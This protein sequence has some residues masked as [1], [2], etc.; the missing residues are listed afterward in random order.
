LPTKLSFISDGVV[1]RASVL[2]QQLRD[3]RKS[4]GVTAMATAEAAGMSR[5]TWHRIEKGA[6]SVTLG[7]WLSAVAVLGLDAE[8]RQ[9]PA[10][11]G[12]STT[13]PSG[14]ESIP[15]R[16]SFADYP[17]LKLLAWQVQGVDSLSPREALNIYERNWRHLDLQTMEPQEQHLI[18]ALQQVFDEDSGNV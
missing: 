6:T 14:L 13:D 16:I 9:P 4:L 5:V 8:I 3:R 18:T 15:V 10:E 11:N 1:A 12:E 17:Q 7:A 2:G